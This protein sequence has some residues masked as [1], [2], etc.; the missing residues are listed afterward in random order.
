MWTHRLAGGALVALGLALLVLQLALL[1]G[2]AAEQALMVSIGLAGTAV[3]S[4]LG[5]V[6]FAAGCLLAS[7]PKTTVHH[8]R[9]AA[10]AVRSAQRR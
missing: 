1:Y 2:S 6:C 10:A 3:L 7:A 4:T 8:V 9:R 5:A